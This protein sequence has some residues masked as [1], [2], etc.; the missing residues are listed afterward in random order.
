MWNGNV[1][2][3]GFV[4]M[5]IRGGMC[6]GRGWLMAVTVICAKSAVAGECAQQRTLWVAPAG[7]EAAEM[8]PERR[9]SCPHRH[10]PLN[11]DLHP[12]TLRQ[13]FCS[14]TCTALDP[15]I[16]RAARFDMFI[17]FQFLVQA[18]RTLHIRCCSLLLPFLLRARPGRGAAVQCRCAAVAFSSR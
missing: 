1:G 15:Q 4:R 12:S 18:S 11:C 5:L 2:A 13:R 14:V 3:V 17:A 9:C 8:Q 7:H 16:S 6:A 10:K